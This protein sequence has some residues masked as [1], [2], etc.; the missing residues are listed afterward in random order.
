MTICAA[1]G[2]ENRAEARFCDACG[3]ALEESAP[4]REVRKTVTVLFADVVGSTAT[5]EERDPEAVRAQMGRWFEQARATIERHGGTV[6]KFAGDAVM[7]VFGV[8]VVHED[9]A[10]R[11]VRSADELRS[12]ELRIGVN[13]GEVIAGEGET[14]VT[15][16]A[17][18][19]AA[20]LEQSAQPG[21]VRIGPE[22]RKLVRDAVEV[23]QLAPLEL[24]GK[25]APVDAY[26]LLAVRAG[27]EAIAR[28]FEAPLVGRRRELDRLRQDFEHGKTERAC[29]LFTLLGP[30]GVGKSRLVAEF[31]AGVDARVV[32]G[33]CL[34]YGE[35]ITYFPVVEVLLQLGSEPDSLIASSPPETELAF[36]KLLEREAGERPLVVVF[37]DIQ[38]AEPTFLDLVEHVADLSRGAPLFL[39]CVA[40]PDLLELRPAW[41]GGKLNATTILLEP[42]A[43]A[44]CEQLIASLGG[45]NDE[46][47]AKVVES[48]EGNPLFVEEMVA[49][50]RDEGDVAVPPTIHALLQARL[51]TL[52]HEERG[53]V[54]RGAVE[55]QVF[56]RGAV[57][58]LAPGTDVDAQLPS[59]V[60]K[61]LIRPDTPTFPDDDAY[62]F[63]HLLIRDAAYDSLPKEIRAELHER[64]A[65]W[66]AAHAD[67][68]EQD[69]IL[70]YHLE[71]AHRYRLELAPADSETRDLGGRAAERLAAG[72]ARALLRGDLPAG[73][74]LLSRAVDLL[75]ERDARRTPLLVDLG[76]ALMDFG[77]LERAERSLV[78]AIDIAHDRD[79]R[80]LELRALLEH[81]LLRTLV[82]QS[83][84]DDFKSTA[85][86][87]IDELEQLGDEAALAK[88]WAM[89][90]H[91]HLMEMSGGAMAEAL[92][93]SI[94]HARRAGD[95]KQEIESLIW[96]L[97]NCWFGPR[98]VDEGIRLCN[99]LLEDPE[100]EPGLESVALQVLGCLLGM[101]GD[102]EEGRQLLRR[103]RSVQIDLGM[104]IAVAAGN[105][106]MGSELELLAGDPVASEAQAREG[107]EIL[108]S[109]GEKG[110]LST[111][112]GH[113]AEA[114]YEQGRYDEAEEAALSANALGSPEDVETHRRWKAVEAKILARRGDFEE[115]AQLGREAV[116]LA[117]QTD[118]YSRADSRLNLAEVLMI[119]GRSDEASPLLDE[120]IA[121]YEQKGMVAA[122]RRARRLV[123][124]L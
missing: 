39:L 45:A 100:T 92:E 36:R 19:V 9:D 81:R 13:T 121:L 116:S 40:R 66:L 6:E 24:K 101:R 119:A 25:A 59:L 86:E 58:E 31:L 94:E 95:R 3:A 30:A 63:R 122:A 23:E 15:G 97:R 60:R 78:E 47:R 91:V 99:A 104:M 120:A 61:E 84:F 22:T 103:A 89:I 102:F 17:V 83:V 1:C 21:E 34:P 107:Y 123:A 118:S 79:Q 68:V 96:L 76:R 65:G 57:V 5:G 51:D 124:E 98:P 110:Y 115:A 38:W 85:E 117:D 105:S 35:G 28:H 112:A 12:P 14:L 49:M 10:L 109:M 33:R 43:P 90:A 20:R 27:A 70:G 74:N 42:L 8:P 29:H 41:G 80:T 7:A 64:F 111:I 48:S 50:L 87:A 73:T 54:E 32:R 88:G 93:R 114:L 69:E 113:L 55:G 106:M 2:A 4:A 52:G 56:H 62:R 67:L 53:V 82:D 18:N 108:E 75:P 37:E 46:M 16:D 71:Q 26:R 72:G 11:A 44:E 77:Q